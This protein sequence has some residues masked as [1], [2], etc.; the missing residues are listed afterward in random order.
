MKKRGFGP[1]VVTGLFLLFAL[2]VGILF[3]NLSKAP[4]ITAAECPTNIGFQLSTISGEEQLCYDT[5]SKEIRFTIENGAVTEIQG[6]IVSIN[7][8]QLAELTDLNI[9]K[10]GTYI[11]TVSYD[12]AEFNTVGLIPLILVEGEAQRCA[13]ETIEK[14]DVGICS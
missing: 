8:E 10:A 11:G 5:Q 12:T 13:R 7:G 14:N 4:S 3:F 6:I 2:A 9:K 1:K